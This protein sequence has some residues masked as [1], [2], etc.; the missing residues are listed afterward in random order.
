MT[1]PLLLAHQGGWD[2]V[3]L[4]LTPIAIFAALLGLANRR[5]NTEVR[6]RSD[7]AAAAPP[8]GAPDPSPGDPG[9]EPDPDDGPGRGPAPH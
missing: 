5:A 1:A 4:I 3:L 2:E 9:E 7:Q 8:R 6:A